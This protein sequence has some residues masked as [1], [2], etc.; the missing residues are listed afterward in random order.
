MGQFPE[1]ST[2]KNLCW[3]L[4]P[5]PAWGAGMASQKGDWLGVLLRGSEEGEQHCDGH[6]VQM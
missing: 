6:R 5:D 4:P 3:V 1:V 2:H